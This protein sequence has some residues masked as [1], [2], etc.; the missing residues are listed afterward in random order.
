MLAQLEP[1]TADEFL[2]WVDTQ[3]ERYEFDGVRP[4]AMTGASI[5]HNLIAG[6][7]RAALRPGLRGTTCREF[8]SDLAVRTVGERLRYP[9]ALVACGVSLQSERIARDVVIVFEVLSPESG[10]RDRIEKLQ[11]Y[12][13]VPSIRRYVI[14]EST[15]AGLLVLHRADG[16][17]PW[18]AMALT[19][20]DVLALPE[21][22]IEIP[23]AALYEDVDFAD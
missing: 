8:G 17:A 19:G 14:V 21:V 13:A 22:G 20:P 5:R 23:V 7:I 9:D 10:R 3:E 16:A 6:N 11:E 12:A 2:R 4:V 15:A 1:W 18:T